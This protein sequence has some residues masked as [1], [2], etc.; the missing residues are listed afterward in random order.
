[1]PSIIQTT[2]YAFLADLIAVLHLLYVIFAVGGE[3]AVV[4]GAIFRWDWIRNKVFRLIHLVA[5]VV[6]AIEALIGVLCPLTKWEYTL[7][8][9]AG[10]TATNNMTFVARLVHKLIFYDFPAWVFTALYISFG[11]LVILTLVLVPPRKKN[12]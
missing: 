6:V 2:P 7:R 8:S 10:Q 1:M 5:V 9:M 12:R 3:I 4:A 11:G